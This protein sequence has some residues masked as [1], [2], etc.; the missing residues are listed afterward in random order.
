L[1]KKAISVKGLLLLER[2]EL[3]NLER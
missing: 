3:V 2:G 1:L